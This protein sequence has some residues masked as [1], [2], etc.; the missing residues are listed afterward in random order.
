MGWTGGNND[1]LLEA[2]ELSAKKRINPSLMVTHVGGL[3][4]VV[5]TTKNL[6][7]I[8]GGKKLIY[9]QIEMPLTAIEDFEKLKDTDPL[10]EKLA[11]AVAKSNGCWNKEAEH[12]LLNHFNV[13]IK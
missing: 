8:P 2:L 10:F 1:D 9:T 4:S 7:F 6:P 3:D 13:E 5:E 12:A 11:N